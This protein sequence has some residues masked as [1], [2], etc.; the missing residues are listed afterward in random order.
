MS[1]CL[2]VHGKSMYLLGQSRGFGHSLSRGIF[3]RVTYPFPL[4]EK[5][6]D[7]PKCS[8][9]IG[10]CSFNYARKINARSCRD[11]KSMFTRALLCH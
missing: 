5:K 7:V 8:D 3:P 9:L 6:L 1:A 2:V 4:S 11:L 10:M